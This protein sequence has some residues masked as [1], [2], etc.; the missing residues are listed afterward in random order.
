MCYNILISTTTSSDLTQF[1]T[2]LVA[3]SKAPPNQSAASLLRHPNHWFLGSIYGCSC[4][5]RHLDRDNEDLGFSEPQD[6]WPEEQEAIDATLEIHDI[7][8][9]LLAQGEQLDCVDCWTEDNE[10]EARSIHGV[11]DINLR[12]IPRACFR[13]L[14]GRHMRF[15]ERIQYSPNASELVID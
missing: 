13:F 1:N 6:W 7:F 15:S 2:P 3:F 4:G 10:M 5:F 8:S 11:A 9:T 14:G 12:E